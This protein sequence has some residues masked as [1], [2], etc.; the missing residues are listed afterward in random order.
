MSCWEK[1]QFSFSNSFNFS[2]SFIKVIYA[3][4]SE[5]NVT[6]KPTAKYNG[7]LPHPLHF[8]EFLSPDS[9]TLDSSLYLL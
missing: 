6:K 7:S 4:D 5:L 8:S 2:F 3:H 1:C 9:A